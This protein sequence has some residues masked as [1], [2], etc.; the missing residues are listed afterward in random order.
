MTKIHPYYITDHE[1]YAQP[2]YSAVCYENGDLKAVQMK[3]DSPQEEPENVEDLTLIQRFSR[4]RCFV[5]TST[6][7]MIIYGIL[8]VVFDW[9]WVDDMVKAEQ[10][11]VFGQ[12][13]VYM[14]VLLVIVAVAGTISFMAEIVNLVETTFFDNELLDGNLSQLLSLFV[15]EIP[16]ITLNVLLAACHEIPI[17]TFQ[18]VKAG[19]VFI[20]SSVRLTKVTVLVCTVKK[21]KAK[22]GIFPCLVRTIIY[23]ACLYV[24]CGGILTFI[25]TYTLHPEEDSLGIK[26]PS[27][28]LSKSYDGARYFYKSGIYFSH[29]SFQGCSEDPDDTQW[30]QL[31]PLMD[32]REGEETVMEVLY[33]YNNETSLI[34]ITTLSSSSCFRTNHPVGNTTSCHVLPQDLTACSP[35]G[36]FTEF[37]SGVTI[38][39]VFQEVEPTRTL[40]FGDITFKGIV[41]QNTSCAVL[42]SDKWGHLHGENALSEYHGQLQ[43]FKT[44]ENINDTFSFRLTQE[45]Q[46]EHFSQ[47]KH[48]LNVTQAWLTGYH[49]CEMS[50]SLAPNP[51]DAIDVKC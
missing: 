39:F 7:L 21:R 3:K 37:F 51:S 34:S 29:P 35:Q 12:P 50:G 30:I 19:L 46:F 45:G 11:L 32:F 2:V 28:I 44:R 24:F 6:S 14:I 13:P 4:T 20:G 23:A 16:Q 9:L 36:N 42:T 43:Y 33:V 8:S 40:V 27:T 31:Q 18:M 26:I 1:A 48:L 15:E 38:L 5:L 25:F 22:R 17:S 49:D 47:K 10:S 41:E